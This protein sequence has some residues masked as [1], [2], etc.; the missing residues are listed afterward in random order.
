MTGAY[1]CALS[2]IIGFAV[3]ATNVS[4]ESFSYAE[5]REYY[6]QQIFHIDATRN[7]SK[8]CCCESQI[9]GPY[10]KVHGLGIERITNIVQRLFKS[11]FV[12]GAGRDQCLCNTN[13]AFNLSLDQ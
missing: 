9:F 11:F 10:R 12:A 8:R 13:P 2:Q 6:A 7:A 4:R 5:F 3:L 1:P